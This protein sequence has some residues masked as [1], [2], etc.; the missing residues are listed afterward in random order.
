MKL[1]CACQAVMPFVEESQLI[2]P[3][4]E[5]LLSDE[6]RCPQSGISL[7]YLNKIKK[8]MGEWPFAKQAEV[9]ANEENV[10]LNQISKRE[11]EVLQYLDSDYRQDE[12][13]KKLYISVTTL[14]FHL[15][16]IY[17]KLKVHNRSGAVLRA[18]QLG[19]LNERESG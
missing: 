11:Y 2:Q 13:A 10:L 14:R 6:I 12:V 5:K 16:N 15:R 17:R 1:G 19:I 7:G 3:I 9:Q 8:L 18:K 4:F